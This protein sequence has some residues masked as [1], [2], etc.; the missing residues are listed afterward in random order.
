MKRLFW[1]LVIFSC[2]ATFAWA[3]ELKLAGEFEG[4]KL[5][6]AGKINVV[7]MK[8]NFYQMGRQYGELMKNEFGE[9][10]DMMIKQ[11]GIGT[12]KA[13]YEVVLAD[14]KAGLEKTPFYVRE[15]VRGMGE[16]SNL[17]ADK[18]I[19]A[20]QGLMAILFSGGACSGMI[21]W[22]PYTKDGAT[23]VGRNWDLGTKALE[24]YQKFLTVAVFNPT[25]YGQS[26]ADIN[27]LGQIM[28]QSG[29]NQSG[30][31]YDLQ[32][33]AMCDPTVAKNRLSS[34]SALMSM[35]LES[36]S[37]KQVDGFFDAVRSEGGLLINVADPKQG[38][39]FEWGTADYRKR[40]DDGTGLVASANNFTD[41]SWRSM[42]AIPDG[43]NGG[44][45]KER[46]ANLLAMGK[47]ERGQ[48][49]AKKMMEIFSTTIPLGGPTFP[50]EGE[51]KTY[52]SIV[53]VPKDLKLWL[54][55]RGLQDWTEIDL[56][57]MFY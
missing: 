42:F 53:A 45:T 8:G 18:Q 41:P 5:Y 44:F 17:G 32:N 50:V 27:Y 28:W 47:K 25:G 34:N 46:T 22:G 37:F 52:Y 35:L 39:C 24:P 15:W 56:K 33:G 48:I 20:S 2:M 31:F 3:E 26:V 11:T 49:D 1:L 9:F 29:I 14:C 13:P 30:I 57:T 16:T 19:I 36:T 6:R 40:V 4:G 12:S 7:V 21:A 10:Y 55:V 38:A 54:N 51:L 23:V 43:K